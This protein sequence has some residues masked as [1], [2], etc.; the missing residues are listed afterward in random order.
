MH[1]FRTSAELRFFW[2]PP[3]VDN[4]Y[5]KFHLFVGN[6]KNFFRLLQG[7][8]LIFWRIKRSNQ[9]ETDQKMLPNKL[10]LSFKGGIKTI[11]N[12]QKG[13]NHCTLLNSSQPSPFVDFF[14]GMEL[15]QKYRYLG[16]WHIVHC[17]TLRWKVC[18]KCHK[19]TSLPHRRTLKT[20][21][22]FSVVNV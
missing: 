7:A 18:L 4:F 9:V 5:K 6:L 10:V 19:S 14:S 15:F 11:L 22:L 8:V 1:L 13:Q 21:G 12:L 17:T 3:F 20:T 2:Y 16:N